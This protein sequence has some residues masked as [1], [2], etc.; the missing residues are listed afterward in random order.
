VVFGK[1]GNAAT[2]WE[3][4]LAG[5]STEGFVI[6]GFGTFSG[7]GDAVS[8]AGDVNGDGLA[9]LLIGAPTFGQFLNGSVGSP[10]EGKAYLVFGKAGGTAVNLSEV[11]NGIGGFVMD[12][13]IRSEGGSLTAAGDING[14]GFAD[15]LIGT[16]NSGFGVHVVYGSNQFASTVDFVGGTGNDTKTGTSAAET[17]VAGAGNDTLYGNGGAD[18][19]NGGAGNDTFVLNASNVTALQ[20]VLGLGGNVGQLARVDGGT[21]M[22][23]IQLSGGAT[24][25][26]TIIANQGMLDP[27]LSG[28]RIASVEVID[29]KT[30]GAANILSLQTKDVVDMA[31][32][33]LFNI[34]NVTTP[35]H[36]LAILGDALDTV[37]TGAGWTVSNTLI[38]YEGHTLVVYNNS[39]SAAQLLIEQAIV[40]ANHVV[41]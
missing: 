29:L 3:G 10:S 33:N 5:N 11:A 35:K 25:D 26:L 6:N 40:N 16:N 1:T 31:G 14:D 27:S 23:T 24:L 36:Q 38:S 34:G 22:D 19:M 7:T 17:F 21:G 15:L 8:S 30:D 39:T 18:V 32:M 12:G 20:N 13:Y 2:D 41:I 28:S 9:D 37:H 4:I